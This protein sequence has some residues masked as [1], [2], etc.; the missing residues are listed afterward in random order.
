MVLPQNLDLEKVEAEFNNGFVEISIP[1]IEEPKR[2]LK[3][4][5]KGAAEPKATVK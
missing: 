2:A 3:V 4:P 1:K 5:I